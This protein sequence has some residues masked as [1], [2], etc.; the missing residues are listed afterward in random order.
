M[1]D[2]VNGVW[3]WVV[4]SE[5]GVRRCRGGS[6]IEGVEGITRA[7]SL[8]RFSLFQRKTL[9]DRASGM[10]KKIDVF[11]VDLVE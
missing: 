7:V 2:L 10:G 1:V 6:E 9:R 4:G 11:F 3:V 5:D 8:R